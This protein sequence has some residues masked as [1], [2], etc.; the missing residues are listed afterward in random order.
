M[1]ASP[2]EDRRQAQ[3][4]EE[5]FTRL[6]RIAEALTELE[7]LCATIDD[8]SLSQWVGR[9]RTAATGAG[10]RVTHLR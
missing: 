10:N 7:E 8:N 5:A 2:H 1:S 4:V 9:M 3:A 6:G